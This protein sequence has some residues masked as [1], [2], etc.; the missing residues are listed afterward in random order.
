MRKIKEALRLSFELQLGQREI[1]R[2]CSVATSTPLNI[3]GQC[4]SC[5][6][7]IIRERV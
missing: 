1:A 4:R 2:A 6:F 3:F 7:R 5:W